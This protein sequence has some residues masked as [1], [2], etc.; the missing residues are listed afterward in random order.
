MK[1]RFV[2]LVL[3]GGLV[4]LAG[5]GSHCQP[6]SPPPVVDVKVARATRETLQAEVNA[7]A[8][9]YGRQQA[10]VAAR[11]T[12]PIRRLLVRKG[13]SVAAGQVLA[14]LEDR[15][16]LAQRA[17]AQAAV[18]DAEAT[19]EKLAGAS[20]PA[21]LERARGQLA[22]AEAA[23]N[24]AQKIYERRQALY[25][26][27]AIPGRDLLVSETE[28]AQARANYEVAKTSLELLTRQTR[29]RE[30]RIAESRLAQARARLAYIETQIEFTRLRSP[31]GGVII[32]Q[33]MFPGDMARP[34]A[35]VFEVADLSV[36]VARAQVP[37][38]AAGPLRVG[39]PCSFQPVDE[40]DR[41]Y[42]G[43]VGVVNRA[44]HPERRT[45][46]VWCEVPNHRNGIRTGMFG[47]VTIVTQT[48]PRA[49]TL[50]LSAVEFVE[51]TDRGL[52][53][54]V[55]RE[56]AVRVREVATGLRS[57]G[58]VQVIGGLDESELVIIE[59]GYGLADGTPVRFRE[60][61]R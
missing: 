24:Q 20:L 14:E 36:A 11:I 41:R 49:L 52:V 23:F 30:I 43:R 26:Q 13:D 18:S 39:Q 4:T 28:L 1:H 16:L 25:E 61:A 9:V 32:E 55:A 59:G 5:C 50:P 6:E 8:T 57:A 53:R 17:E 40:P 48:I 54:V 22:A 19:L 51:G 47:E 37:E 44:V 21:D 58:K 33:Y 7:P 42:A 46:E 45:V 38:A 15:D 29:D 60:G 34:D 2:I 56:R 27:G 3:L 12:A 31:F 35:P 10:G